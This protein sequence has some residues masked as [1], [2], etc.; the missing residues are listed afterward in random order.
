MDKALVMLRKLSMANEGK[1]KG[2]TVTVHIR[3][4]CLMEVTA[5]VDAMHRPYSPSRMWI[6]HALRCTLTL[7]KT[8]ALLRSAFQ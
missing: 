5:H 8:F 2:N 7:R 4:A 6:H 1:Y 3:Q